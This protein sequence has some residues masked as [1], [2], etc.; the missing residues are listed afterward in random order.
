VSRLQCVYLG[1]RK[2]YKGYNVNSGRKVIHAVGSEA[3]SMLGRTPG[4]IEAIR[5]MKDGVIADFKV[6]EEM[7]KY[8][9]KKVKSEATFFRRAKPKIVIC[10]P[11]GATAVERR[12]IHQSAENACQYMSLAGRWLLILAAVQ[13]R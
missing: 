5:P 10:V 8:F 2:D 6:A 11:S 13:Q 4:N 1:R 12:A 9:I 7:I 3:R